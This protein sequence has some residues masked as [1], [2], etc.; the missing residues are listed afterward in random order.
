[1]VVNIDFA[2]HFGNL[3]MFILVDAVKL[4][5]LELLECCSEFFVLY[6]D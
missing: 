1:M 6:L 2:R 5:L 3:G 4:M